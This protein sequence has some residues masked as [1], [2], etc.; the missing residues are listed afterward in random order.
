[1]RQVNVPEKITRAQLLEFLGGLGLS[2][3]NLVEFNVHRSAIE[4]KVYALDA[5]GQKY[6]KAVRIDGQPHGKVAIDTIHIPIVDEG[7]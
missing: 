1:M 7:E 2:A 5:Q 6:V 3:D 4:A